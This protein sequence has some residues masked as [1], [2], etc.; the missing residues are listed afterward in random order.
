MFSS[1]SFIVSDLTFRSFFKKIYLFI[2]LFIYFWLHWVGLHCCAQAFSSCG[3]RGPL[4]I[5][6]CGLLTAVACLVAEHGL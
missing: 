2:Y 5:A 1:K 3:K 4:S 6:V